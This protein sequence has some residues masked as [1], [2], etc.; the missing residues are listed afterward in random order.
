[1]NPEKR[2][3]SFPKLPKGAYLRALAGK[4]QYVL[5]AGLLGLLLLLWPQGTQAETAGTRV[6]DPQW[7]ER[8]ALE[9]RLC[10]LLEEVE[11]V[12]QVRVALT[13]AESGETVYARDE[14]RAADQSDAGS[15][16]SQQSQLVHLSSGSGQEP[17]P[18]SQR[19]PVYRGAVVVCQGAGSPSVCLN[20]TRVVQSLTGLSADKIVIT[21]MK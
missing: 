9:T 1:M 13:L 7:E 6:S 15:S 12:G 8:E 10:A 16:L 18:L 20:V 11:G 5:L 14:S 4:Y 3:F 19:A 17:V 21:K 2:R